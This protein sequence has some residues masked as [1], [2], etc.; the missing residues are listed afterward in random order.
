SSAAVYGNADHI[1]VDEDQPLRPESPYASQKALC[2]FYC[3][4]FSQLF[5]LETVCLRYF[6]VFGPRQNQASGYAAAIPLLVQAALDGR[7]PIVYGDG[8]QTRDFVYVDDVVAANLRAAGAE[9]ATGRVFNIG[10]GVGI[11]VLG[12]IS[13]LE[14]SI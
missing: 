11:S 4:N 2:E 12:L 8:Q 13:E 10:G 6:N 7:K 9:G 3:H 5:G 1:P 14:R